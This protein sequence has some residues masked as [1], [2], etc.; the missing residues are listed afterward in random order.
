[1]SQINISEKYENLFNPPVGVDTFVVTGG[2]FSQK[3]FAVALA[4]LVWSIRD[5]HR[6]MF[7]RFTN[8]SAADS[9]IPEIE[10]KISLMNYEKYFDVNKARITSTVNDSKIVFKGMKSGSGNQTANLKGLKDFSVWILD[11]AEELTDFEIAEKTM[12]SVRGNS[13][14]SDHPNMKVLIMNPTTK[15]HWVYEKYFTEKGVSAGYNGVKGNICYIHTSYLDCLE[16]VPNDFLSYFN[17]M[18]ENNPS[19]YN[20][21]ILGG[22]LDKAEGVIF[23]KWK[24]GEFQECDINGY[25][26]DFGFSIDPTALV[27]MSID[28]KRK[29]C[30]WK[31][32]TY[33][34]GLS[35]GQIFNECSICGDSLIIADSA[36]P[37]L[38]SELKKLGLNIKQCKKGPGSVTEG[39]TSMQDYEHII[40]PS[41]DKLGVEFNNY[42]WNDKRSK[43]PIDLY[44]HGIDAGRYVFSRLINKKN[45]FIV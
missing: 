6:I 16:F 3:S 36:E 40:D 9:I 25:G 33:K 18:K 14:G 39:L 7:S 43:T 11:E 13:Q 44:N 19:R 2:R 35:T 20:H 8:V 10:E 5:N 23:E 22:W 32:H 17:E 1:M 38:I 12:L 4:S 45:F 42:V 34:T 41:S 37:R 26:L 30:Y 31:L 29:K 27:Q 28:T 15:T 21:I 24:Y